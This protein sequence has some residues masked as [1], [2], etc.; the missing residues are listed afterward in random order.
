[1]TNQFVLPC[2]GST[3]YLHGDEVKNRAVNLSLCI[4]IE[5]ERFKRYPDSRGKPCLRFYFEQGIEIN[6]VY[7]R[8]EDRDR[9]FDRILYIPTALQKENN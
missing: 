5:K 1:M 9:D 7:H 8:E 6:W 2:I 4:A 3:I